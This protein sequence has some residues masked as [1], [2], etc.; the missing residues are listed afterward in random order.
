MKKTKLFS[1]LF[2]A[3]L[4]FVTNVFRVSAAGSLQLTIGSL[5]G[6]PG[7]TIEVPIS[8]SNVPTNGIAGC[9]FSITFDKNNLELLEIKPGDVI[10]D[11]SKDFTSNIKDN[12]VYFLFIDE[13]STFSRLIKNN[14]VFAK[15]VF[16]IKSTAKGGKYQ[17]NIKSV[18]SFADSNIK[19]VTYTTKNGEITV[20]LV[21]TNTT[22]TVTNKKTTVQPPKKYVVVKSAKYNKNSTITIT[23]NTN[24]LAGSEYSKITLKYSSGKRL[25]IYKS[26]KGNRLT[27]KSS[28]KFKKKKRYTLT[29]T[30]KAIKDKSKNCLKTTYKYTFTFK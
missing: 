7:E 21:A 12:T 16:K 19:P 22:K 28:T 5:S 24:I 1:I 27:I 23:F 9:D 25:K 20:N 17:I 4:I 30:T 29:I 11:S 15:L 13:T 6:K 26:L 8:L 18:G 2:F 10:K 14:G 3:F